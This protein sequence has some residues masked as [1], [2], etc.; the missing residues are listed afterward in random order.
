MKKALLLSLALSLTLYSLR[1]TMYRWTDKHILVHTYI[2]SCY[3]F[4]IKYNTCVI[5]IKTNTRRNMA[6]GAY[7]LLLSSMTITSCFSYSFH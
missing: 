5:A 7:L 4:I 2:Y 3:Y 1:T 6:S